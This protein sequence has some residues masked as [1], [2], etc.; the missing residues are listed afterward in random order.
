MPK[1][2]AYAD[3]VRL[4]T[5][6][7]P[8]AEAL[9][10]AASEL[11]QLS[12]VAFAMANRDRQW[13]TAEDLSADLAQLGLA[14][15][16][17]DVGFAAP[18][19]AG[20]RAIARFFF[21]HRAQAVR[22]GR[23]LH[24]YE[25]LHATFGEFLTA[26]LIAQ[27]LA[28]V[29][30]RDVA[31]SRT[32]RPYPAHD[33]LLYSLL[34]FAPLSGQ[35]A[36]TLDFLAELVPAADRAA[37]GDWL[38]RAFHLATARLDVPRD[39]YLPAPV[40]AGQRLARYGLNLVLLALTAG[41][42][43]AATEL[44]PGDP[45]PA[46]RLGRTAHG[47]QSTL[48]REQ[49]T[50]LVD[51]VRVD[52]G[53]TG[54]QRDMVLSRSWADRSRTAGAFWTHGFGPA[55]EVWSYDRRSGFNGFASVRHTTG[56]IALRADPGEAM[57]DHALEPLHELLAPALTSFVV[58]GAQHAESVARSLVRAWI[59][60]VHPQPKVP[61]VAAF[62]NLVDAACGYA[63]GEGRHW[64]GSV[65]IT[66]T[67]EMLSACNDR[68]PRDAVERWLRQIV[69]C[70]QFASEHV[71]LV[72]NCIALCHLSDVPVPQAAPGALPARYRMMHMIS[73][74]ELGGHRYAIDRE[75]ADDEIEV[76]RSD[77]GLA[78]RYRALG[79]PAPGPGTGQPA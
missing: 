66:V 26:R 67:L 42:A 63:W 75:L 74:A 39:S 4:L 60:S 11:L 25:F 62:D 76:L 27:I 6:A 46:D 5:D 28:D 10:T 3:A 15:P 45:D 20:E 23:E 70:D 54:A 48:T 52:T 56:A 34:S 29:V 17:A 18:Q 47:W 21:I 78:A 61:L 69:E 16:A 58:H 14:A 13:V 40:P 51:A 73:E 64:A 7:S 33:D 77:R 53:W 50:A 2:L 43:V 31:G 22:Q 36:T 37:T 30:A 79:Y 19:S 71:P 1:G 44:F 65:T 9:G 24:T 72:T 49:W 57:Y 59:T 68:L 8:A 55:S 12:V 38:R 41:G 35:G 32:L